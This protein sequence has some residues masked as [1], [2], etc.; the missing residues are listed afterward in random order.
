VEC[1]CIQAPGRESRIREA[2]IK[3]VIGLA[4]AIADVM[5]DWLDGP[6]AIFGHS[7]GGLVGFE[8]AR[9]LRA[10]GLLQPRHLFVSAT[11]AP[12][13]PNPHSPVRD[14]PDLRMLDELNRR[15]DG[16]VPE[17]ILTS[18][19]LRELFVPGLR[20]DFT[21]LETY[22]YRPAEPL[23]CPISVFGGTRDTTVTAAMVQPW[24]AETDA[25][26]EH[27]MFD[28]GHLFLQTDARHALVKAILSTLHPHTVGESAR[29]PLRAASP[30]A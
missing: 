18:P 23:T 15:Y 19:E 5:P 16:S 2:S 20:A 3:S 28:G 1:V 21:A 7:L 14:L 8:L 25:A 10:R 22:E 29:N 17:A 11:R 26:C 13:V 27:R 12:S 6:F 24:A 30:I 9:T 4:E